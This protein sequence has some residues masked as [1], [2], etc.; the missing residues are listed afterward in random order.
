MK[1][2]IIL[3]SGV[4]NEEMRSEY[5]N[6]PAVFL[7]TGRGEVIDE[8]PDFSQAYDDIFVT[9]P[10]TYKL[11]LQNEKKIRDLS[12]QIKRFSSSLSVN[13]VLINVLGC[14]QDGQLDVLFGDTIIEDQLEIKSNNYLMLSETSYSYPWLFYD[15]GT[16]IFSKRDNDSA[17]VVCGCFGFVDI[18]LMRDCLKNNAEL[19]GFLNEYHKTKSFEFIETET[20]RDYGHISTMSKERVAS[21]QSRFFN[22]VSFDLGLVKKSSSDINKLRGEIFWYKNTPLNVKKYLPAFYEEKE[23]DSELCYYTEYIPSST[24]EDLFMYGCLNQRQ[25]GAFF[26]QVEGVL[27]AFGETKKMH[28]SS[29]ILHDLI[30]KKLA[31][32]L[33]MIKQDQALVDFLGLNGFMLSEV[34]IES[35]FRRVEAVLSKI[36]E[37]KQCVMHGDFFFGNMFYNARHNSLKLVDPRGID[38]EGKSSIWGT[39]Y[40]DLVKLAHSIFGLYDHIINEC[41]LYDFSKKNKPFTLLTNRENLETCQSLFVKRFLPRM[42]I[43][44]GE[45]LVLVSTLFIS[46]LPLHADSK[47]R[48]KQLALRALRLLEGELN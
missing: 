36:S 14:V 44:L 46:M 19:D 27:S 45:L 8:F 31:F 2:L 5:G 26:D 30:V 34:A 43:E 37:D 7:P 23:E 13:Q 4:S 24:G 6:I 3:S 28:K 35:F 42:G 39:Q 22:E 11:T 33:D 17:R 41:A 29:E 21:L 32:R 16:D 9:L 10:D 40:Y 18:H 20:W 1:T 38:T 47:D 15:Y 48:Q 25:W 12:F